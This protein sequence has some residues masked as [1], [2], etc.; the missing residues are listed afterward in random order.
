MST[1]Q[2]IGTRFYGWTHHD[3]GTA[4]ATQWF[5]LFFLPVIPLRRY[6]LRVLTDFKAKEPFLAVPKYGFFAGYPTGIQVDHYDLLERTPLVGREIARTLLLTYV[7]G[8][9][10]MVWPISLF[11][12]LSSLVKH[13]PEWKDA[14]WLIYV[15]VALIAMSFGNAIAVPL[16]ALRKTRGF[17][18]GLFE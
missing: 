12:A 1:I 4:H 3:D 7:V 5:A 8:P 15:F 18:G 14:A 11:L 13:N 10:L 9:I 17:R 2:G 16:I 6:H